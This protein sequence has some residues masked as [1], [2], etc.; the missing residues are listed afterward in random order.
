MKKW[1]KAVLWTIIGIFLYL[2]TGYQFAVANWE[3]YHSYTNQDYAQ[4]KGDL[5]GFAYRGLYPVTAVAIGEDGAILKSNKR[6]NLP[7]VASLEKNK[8]VRWMTFSWGFKILHNALM[9]LMLAI[10]HAAAYLIV[11]VYS[12]GKFIFVLFSAPFTA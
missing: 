6:S 7:P 10:L 1:K 8:Y 9:Y 5:M 2:G 3:I 12:L 11:I 4:R